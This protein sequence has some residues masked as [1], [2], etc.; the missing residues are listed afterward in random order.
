MP[1]IHLALQVDRFQNL[2]KGVRATISFFSLLGITWVFGAL[3]IS[4]ASVAFF[5]LF[6][7]CNTVQGVF[8]FLFHCYFD[9]KY[10][11]GT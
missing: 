8:L 1:L 2:K 6:A 7:I 9:V 11:S 5:Y 3:A 10:D 4:D